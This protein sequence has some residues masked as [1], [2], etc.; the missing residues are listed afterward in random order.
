[1]RPNGLSSTL[2]R[3]NGRAEPIDA[4]PLVPDA[5]AGTSFAADITTLTVEVLPPPRRCVALTSPPMAR[6]SCLTD[7]NP[8]PAPPK[9]DAIETL[10]CE[11]GRNRRLISASVRPIPL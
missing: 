10:A 9:R 6:A 2:S 3:R 4:S 7:D 8:S 1:T 5:T 11:N